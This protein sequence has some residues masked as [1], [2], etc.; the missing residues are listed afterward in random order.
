MERVLAMKNLQAGKSPCGTGR[1]R[2]SGFTLIEMLLVVVIL[3]IAA[4]I[5]VPFATSGAS[6]QLK[7]AATIIAS[8]LEYAKSMA[9]SHG[10]YYSVEFDPVNES[11]E[12]QDVNGTV[13]NHPVKKGSSYT[14]N[15]AND[16]R[17]NQVDIQSTNFSGNT[18]AFDYLG[19][20]YSGS[21]PL[22]AEGEIVISAGGATLTVKVEPVTGY[23]TVS[24]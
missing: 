6:T 2:D 14:I 18:V 24:D 12:I 22:L 17:L 15:F 8:D 23:I 3:S 5:A 11:Y 4:M 21:S 13:I 20:S 7:S 16:S 1:G 9:I 19:S 10:N